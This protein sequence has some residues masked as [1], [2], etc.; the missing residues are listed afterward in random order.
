M[1]LFHTVLNLGWQLFP[2]NGSYFDQPVVAMIMTGTAVVVTVIWGPRTLARAGHRAE[3][4]PSAGPR[5]EE[6]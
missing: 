1:V 4:V 2:V 6:T 3:W 5:P